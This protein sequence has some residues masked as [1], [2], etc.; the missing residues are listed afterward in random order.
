MNCLL[1][2]YTG[3]FNTRYLTELLKE[4]LSQGGCSVTAY[5]IDPLNTEKLD[6]SG[7]D[8]LG[9]G[10]PIYGFNA[11][12]P[13]IKFLKRQK[14]PPGLRVFIYKN[15]GETYPV[16]DA[17]SISVLRILHRNGVDVKNEY[18][19]IMPY[20]IH[21]RFEEPLVREMLDI[22][23]LLMDILVKEIFS[24]IPNIKKY[25]L[26]QRLITFFVKLQFIGGDI[27]S[28]FYRV[29]KNQCIN[30]GLCIKN[31]PMKNI[32]RDKKGNIHFRHHCLMC[33]R[34]SMFC[35]KDAIRIGILDTWGWRVNG[36][37]DF[38]Q[39]RKLPLQEVINDKTE[40]FYRC[41]VQTYKNIRS[42]HKELFGN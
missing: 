38:E 23:G 24:G 5:E 25:R 17:S 42:R 14:I 22:D 8:I 12:F 37:Y 20:N 31:C 30:C 35:P 4:R 32:V 33:M 6:F 10:Y 34:C 21:F 28:F 13:F 7:Y 29:E 16:N 27:N 11:P 39:I 9:L 3:T 15:S 18:H 41:Y 40:G 19:F 1:V 2:Y 26:Y 36:P